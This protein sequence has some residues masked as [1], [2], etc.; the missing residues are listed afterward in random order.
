MGLFAKKITSAALAATMTLTALPISAF[1]VSTTAAAEP[2]GSGF[3]YANG[4]RFMVDG[5]P[6]YYAGTNCYY[7]TFKSQ[8]AVDNVFKDAEAMGLKVIRVWG[9]LDV[10]VKTG[11]TDSEGKP[12]FTNNNDGPGEKDG[13][14][15]QYFDKDLGKPVTNFGEDGIKKLDYALYQAEKHGIKLLIT[16]TNYWDAFG[17]MGQYVNWAEEIGITGL[18][19][20]DFYTNETLKGWYK[21]YVSGLLN[22]TNPYTNRK[23]KD[24]PSVFAWELANEPRCKTDAQCKDNILYNWAKEMSEYVKSIDPNHMVSLGDEGFYNKPYGYYNEYTTSNYAFYGAEGVDF[25]KLMT[26]DTLDFGTPHL[27]LDQ[28]GMK[29][30]GTGQD[31]LLWFKIHGETCAELD[32]PVILEE[33][34][35]TD[36]SIR[37]DEYEQWF[38]VLEGNVYETVEYAG[39]NYWMIASY[40]DGALYPD[41]DQYTVYGPEGTDTETTRQLIMKHAANMEAKNNINTVSP[42]KTDYDRADNTDVVVT[43][44]MKEGTISGVSL[45]GNSLRSGTD[46]TISGNT[47]TIKSSYLSTLELKS[48]VF[49][50]DCTAGSNPKFTITTSDSSIPAPT[51]SKT[52]ATIDKNSRH[53][54][55][56]TISYDKK[57]SEFRGITVN[58]SYLEKGKDYTDNAGTVTFADEYIKSLS[59]GNVTLSF[60]FYEGSDCELLLTVTDSSALEDIDLFENYA[61]SS[62]LSNAYV[63]NT[64]GNS[65]S[66]SLVDRNGGKAMGFGYNV[67]SPNGYSGVNH[68]MTQ[69]DVSA[70][71]GVSLNFKGDGSGNSFTVQ[72]RDKNDNY[73][74]KRITVDSAEETTLNIPF[75][76]FEAPSWQSGSASLDTSGIVQIAFYAGGGGTTDTGTYVIDDVYFYKEGSEDTGAHLINKTGT[77]DAQSPAGVL[78]RLVLNGQAISKITYGDKTL[79]STSDYSWNGSQVAI[80][81]A[82]T[83]TLPNGEHKITY[84]FSDG[85]SDV[86]TLTVINSS[87]TDT[88]TCTYTSKVIK[89]TYTQQGYTIY[90]CSVCGDSYKDNYTDKLTLSA[91]SD[92]KITSVSSSSLTLSWDKNENATGYFI[93]QYKDGEWKHIRQL[94]RNTVTSYTATGLD[95]SASYQFRIRAYVTENS[96]TAYSEYV[97]ISGETTLN[98]MSISGVQATS[99]ANTVTLSWNKND[100]ATGYFVQQY[101]NGA[102]THVRQ[103]ARNTATTYTA[104]GLTP[105]TKYQFRIRAY[106]TDGVSTTYGDYVILSPTTRPNNLTGVKATSTANTVTLSWDKN[107]SATGYFVQQFK[108]GAWTHV[109]QLARNTATTYTATG[110][111]P[112]TTYQFRIRAYYTDGVSTTYSDY[113]TLSPTT[114]PNNLTGVKVTSTAN[115]VKLSWDK[116]DS[117]TGYFVQQYK[118][119]TWTHIR[120]LARNTATTYTATGL[121]P[122]T[123][124]QYRIRAY[125]TD[126][127]S[128]T[129]SDYVTVS[130]KT[131]S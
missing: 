87:V 81:T 16:F 39:T 36:R 33:F 25:E 34:G 57:T 107:D 127:V 44:T 69:R 49:T 61:N 28:W 99:T 29:H 52:I 5:S 110:L 96:A 88:H 72:F 114:R 27:Y 9:N 60:D 119:G 100:S 116:N 58:G 94:A 131:I 47:I 17:G 101:K 129:Y 4:T 77:F 75:S 74:E 109:R 48:H 6:F 65:V 104:S 90:T 51:I 120:Q 91:V 12:V 67:G 20:E 84:C 103:L 46:Y 50:L 14:Y 10:G 31:D 79:D 59:N 102:W 76:E 108:N 112:S 23:L 111:T 73:F 68:T 30:T 92:L 32:K 38:E 70:Y 15:F 95:A 2:T 24:E 8:D 130:A 128:T 78:T 35:L 7:L 3:V 63:A 126:G 93:Q 40:I 83:S 71:T 66:L 85:T 122:S 105:S 41:Y 89:P 117:A 43:A 22:H 97:T 53:Y 82:F 26:I 64:S 121:T 113:V 13:I 11:T 37:N 19:K 55:P 56:L 86:F 42:A 106:Y 18:Q 125:F 80:N 115:T 45:N 98:N 62:A 1:F 54:K 123:T 118:N 124:Y 21:D